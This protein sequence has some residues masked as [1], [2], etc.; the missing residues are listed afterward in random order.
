LDFEKAQRDLWGEGS[1]CAARKQETQNKKEGEKRKRLW[2]TTPFVFLEQPGKLGR[3]RKKS[4][5]GAQ[6]GN[7]QTVE[8][9]ARGSARPRPS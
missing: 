3:K 9:K 2:E 5:D 6:K 8:G 7:Q 4:T 1:R